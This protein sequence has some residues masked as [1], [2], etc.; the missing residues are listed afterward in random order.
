MSQP[1]YAKEKKA[2]FI[3]NQAIVDRSNSRMER[4]PLEQTH[5]SNSQSKVVFSNLIKKTLDNESGAKFVPQ[6]IDSVF[7]PKSMNFKKTKKREGKPKLT[8]SLPPQ[9]IQHSLPLKHFFQQSLNS[10]QLQYPRKIEEI[11]QNNK[12]YKLQYFLGIEPTAHDHVVWNFM[13]G[14]YAYIYDNLIIVQSLGKSRSQRII[15]LPQKLSSLVLTKDFKRLICSSQYNSTR[16]TKV[17]M[18]ESGSASD[19]SSSSLAEG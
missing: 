14:W 2:N 16:K 15:T 7:Q 6:K 12:K 10:S 19:L 18:S 9:N 4:Q 3:K 17:E 13:Y 11:K 8:T 5:K 1:V